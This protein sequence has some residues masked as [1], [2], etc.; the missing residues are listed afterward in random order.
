MYVLGAEVACV[1]RSEAARG[2]LADLASAIKGARAFMARVWSM[3]SLSGRC[4]G[5]GK[6]S[7]DAAAEVV[8]C[9]VKLAELS[10]ER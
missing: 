5:G 7:K 1:M 8:R 2:E 3:S 6:E 4:G 10:P 9:E